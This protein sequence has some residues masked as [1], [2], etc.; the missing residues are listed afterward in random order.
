MVHRAWKLKPLWSRHLSTVVAK[1]RRGGRRACFG[2]VSARFADVSRCQTR[3]H[4]PRRR[5]RDGPRDR[6][7]RQGT[8]SLGRERRAISRLPR[9]RVGA[10]RHRR[11]RH[12]REALPRV[13]AERALLGVDTPQ[14]RR[15]QGRSCRLHRTHRCVALGLQP[16]ERDRSVRGSRQGKTAACNSQRRSPG[17]LEQKRARC[18]LPELVW[19]FR[20]PAR[21]A[22]RS[23]AD[24]DSLSE[25]SKQLAKEL[26]RSGF[27]FVGPTTVYATMQAVGLVNDHL[28]GCFV[29]EEVDVAQRDVQ[30]LFPSR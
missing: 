27:A 26:K 22:P 20:P 28:A 4:A 6:R 24:L 16:T 23:Y 14:T 19:S 5:G 9:Q 10:T 2:A 17:D 25:E 7:G 18:R 8:V 21:K 3:G 1:K 13:P 30:R 11:A 29:R 15:D 12:L